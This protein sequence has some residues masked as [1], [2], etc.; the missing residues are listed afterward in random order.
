MIAYIPNPMP[1]NSLTI[2]TT[3]QVLNML[4]IFFPSLF[5]NTQ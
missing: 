3:P 2:R 5:E 1:T 4:V